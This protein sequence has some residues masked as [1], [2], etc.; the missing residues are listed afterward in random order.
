MLWVG[1]HGIQGDR[2]SVLRFLLA[3]AAVL[4][5]SQPHIFRLRTLTIACIALIGIGGLEFA[6]IRMLIPLYLQGVDLSAYLYTSSDSWKLLMPE[7]SEFKGSYLSILD[8]VSNPH[9]MLLGE[10]YLTSP[11]AL[12]PDALYPGK[13]PED[14][15]DVVSE[16]VAAG[17]QYVMGWTYSPV[18]EAYINFGTLGVPVIMAGWAFLFLWLG[19]MQTRSLWGLLCSAL[20]MQQAFIVHRGDFRWFCGVAVSSTAALLITMASLKLFSQRCESTHERDWFN[21]RSTIGLGRTYS[22]EQDL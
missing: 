15:A 18:A 14:L 22:N 11:L 4:A 16:S 19:S 6:Q 8:A 1:L 20:F 9:G 10:T 7:N 17:D 13:K 2:I 3:M 5:T 12:L 21:M